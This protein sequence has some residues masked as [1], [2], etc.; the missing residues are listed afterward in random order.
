MFQS[1]QSKLFKKNPMKV[2]IF[3]SFLILFFLTTSCE[4]NL[5]EEPVF[6]AIINA[7]VWTANPNQPWAEA[8]AVK[9]NLIFSVGSTA[10]IRSTVPKNTKI[11]DAHARI[12]RFSST[13][14]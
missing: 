2:K 8:I 5:S 1:I 9:D 3:F 6:L 14:Y 7:R 13:S 11:I 4:K 12:Y 10:E